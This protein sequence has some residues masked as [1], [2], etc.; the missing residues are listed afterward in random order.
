MNKRNLLFLGAGYL[1]GRMIKKKSGPVMGIGAVWS[2][3]QEQEV[4]KL[5]K[6]HLSELKRMNIDPYSYEASLLWKK[7][8]QKRF[9]KIFG[10]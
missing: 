3:K 4:K 10:K 2:H 8:Y 1:A 7:K 6:E 9:K 5:D